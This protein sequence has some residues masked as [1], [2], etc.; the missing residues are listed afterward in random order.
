M[1]YREFVDNAGTMWRVW[2]TYPVAANTLRT[3]SPSFAGGW[4]TFE[5]DTERRRLAPIP[6]GWEIATRQLMIHW[7]ARAFQA[8]PPDHHAIDAARSQ[9]QNRARR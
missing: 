5:S 7:C 9:D 1:A 3:V 2:D 4:L 8:R 6:A